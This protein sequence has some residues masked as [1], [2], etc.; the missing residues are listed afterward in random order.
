MQRYSS[1]RLCKKDKDGVVTSVNG[2]GSG[3]KGN[4]S[5][6]QV[7]DGFVHSFSGEY[8]GSADSGNGDSGVGVGDGS[9]GYTKPNTCEEMLVIDRGTEYP[10]AMLIE[11]IEADAYEQYLFIQVYI[12]I[13]M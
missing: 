12:Y 3:D 2:S 1:L 13:Y 10:K 5:G 9:G 6:G 4:G 8:V 11:Y 7:T